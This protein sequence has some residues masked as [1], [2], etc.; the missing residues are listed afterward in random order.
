MW[1]LNWYW[2]WGSQAAVVVPEVPT[3]IRTTDSPRIDNLSYRRPTRR[4]A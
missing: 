3:V 2:R 4:P 1:R